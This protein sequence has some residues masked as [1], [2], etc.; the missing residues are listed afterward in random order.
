MRDLKTRTV[1][2]GLIVLVVGIA[3]FVGGVIGALGSI[4]IQTNFMQPHPGEYVSSE[5]LLNTTSGLVVSFPATTG[6]VI[7]AQDLSR[8][9]STNLG[10]YAIP[11]NSSAG[12]YIYRSLVGDYYYVAF[13][14]T[15]PDTTIVVTSLKGSLVGYGSLVLIGIVCGIV[16]FIIAIIGLFQKKQTPIQGQPGS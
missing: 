2:I 3:L 8:I 12:N 4:S 9:N 6:G 13:S 7:P 14:S 10:T 5:I 11:Y 16:G 15:Q 1:V